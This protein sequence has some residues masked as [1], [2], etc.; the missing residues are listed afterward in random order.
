[1]I[2]MEARHLKIVCDI[3]QKYPYS[4]YAFGSRV[5]NRA[6]K[7]SDLDLC[8]LEAIPESTLDTIKEAFE[9]SD[10]PFTVDILN[11]HKCSPDFQK[12][13]K[14]DLVPFECPTGNN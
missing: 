8:F 13:I 7:F 6:K 12:I 3:L 11:W 14:P 2:V 9:E 4:F 1:M 10:L 5:K